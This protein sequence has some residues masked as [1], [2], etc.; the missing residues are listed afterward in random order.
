[1]KKK[2]Y[3]ILL[4][5]DFYIEEESNGYFIDRPVC[6]I[7]S[8]SSNFDGQAFNI[9]F[10][11]KIDGTHELSFELPQIYLDEETGINVRNPLI[12]LL[13]NKCKLEVQIEDKTYFMVINDRKEDENG[14]IISYSYSC[15]DAFIEELSKTGYGITFSDEIEGNGLG[16]I[17]ELAETI[18][19][20]SDWEYI[21]E[22]TGTLY[23]YT[24]DLSYNINQ[25]RYDK[26]Y[27]PIPVHPVKYIPELERYCNRLNMLR[28][29]TKD[30]KTVYQ[31]IYCY[32]DTEQI[33]SN[34][35]QNLIYNADD[36][37]DFIGWQTYG[38]EEN[39]IVPGVILDT[40]SRDTDNS[41][42][43]EYVLQIHTKGDST[44]Q[45]LLNDT[46]SSA[47]IYIQG[48]KPY[49]FYIDYETSSQFDGIYAI[50]FYSKNPLTNPTLAPE[51]SY[52]NSNGEKIPANTFITL[53]PKV[54]I[55]NPYI[56]F[57]F[58]T[59]NNNL[60]IKK[61]SLFEIKG[62]KTDGSITDDSEQNNLTLL[63][64]L[65]DGTVIS[66]EDLSIM[67]QP[68]DAISAYTQKSVRYFVR[69]NYAVPVSIGMKDF[70]ETTEN[71]LYWHDEDTVTYLD[72][73][74]EVN[75]TANIRYWR[76]P[77][78]SSKYTLNFNSPALKI[79]KNEENFNITLDD[80]DNIQGK[81]QIIYLP[82]DGKYYQYYQVE[83]NGIINGAWDY[84][85]YGVWENEVYSEDT[86][87]IANIVNSDKRR[88]LVTSRSNR[89][90]LIQDLAEL[91]KVWPVFNTYRDPITGK[92]IKQFWFRENCLKENFSGFHKGVNLDK[93]S[94]DIKSDD[95]VTKMYVE[96]QESDYAENGFVT[97]RTSPLNPW[98]ENYYYN[99]QYYVNQ[100]LINTLKENKPIVQYDLDELYTSVK[101][102]N[103][104][105]FDLNDKIANA[106]VELSNLRAR[107]T[108]LATMIAAMAERLTSL[109]ADIKKYESDEKDGVE[110]KDRLPDYTHALNSRSNY[111]TM[112]KKY[113]TEL[114]TTQEAYDVLENEY[115]SWK[116]QTDNLQ[117]EKKNLIDIFENKYSQYIKEGVWSDASYVDNNTYYI[118][119]LKVM[120]TSSMPKTDWTISIID[121]SI[122]DELQEF[123]FE[124]GDQTILVDNE[125]FGVTPNA[126][127]NYVFEVLISGIKEYLDNPTKN[128]IEVRNYL[129]SFEDIFQR[130]SAAT[131]TL[132]LNEQTYNKAAYFTNDGQVDESI[133]QN[134]LLKNTL[135][136][137]NSTDN[138]Y[139]LD[140]T[141]LYLQ[142]IIN[143]AK[144][145]RA[146]AD[147]IFISKETDI[148]TG[149]PKWTTGITADGIN[150]SILTSGEVNTSVVKIFSKGTPNF[151]WNELGITAYKYDNDGTV[152]SNAF[153]RFDSF[154]LYSTDET[155]SIGFNYDSNRQPWFEGLSRGEAITKILNNALVSITDKGF[156]LNVKNGEGSIKLG[157]DDEGTSYGLYI[158]DAEG[159]LTVQLQNDGKNK[160]AGWDIGQYQLS[161]YI[162]ANKKD[163]Q[164]NAL[165][166][167]FGLQTANVGTNALAI[168]L[169]KDPTK[170]WGDASFRV[171]HDGVLHATGADI[172]GSGTFSGV[173]KATSG[174]LGGWELTAN[175]I[176][177]I[178]YNTGNADTATV[179]YE[180]FMQNANTYANI[181]TDYWRAFGIYKNT[182]NSSSDTW[183]STESPF[184]VRSDGY[185]H[186][187]NANI[188]GKI[189]ATSGDF[190]DDVTIGGTSL[191]AEKIRKMYNAAVTGASAA[192]YIKYLGAIGGTVGGWNITDD[193]YL[194]SAGN[195]VV[196]DAKNGSISVSRTAGEDE[197]S[198]EIGN[199]MTSNG[200]I[201]ETPCIRFLDGN[202]SAGLFLSEGVLYV[203]FTRGTYYKVV[204]LATAF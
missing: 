63:A 174:N 68:A 176:R 69:D 156:N 35:V 116:Q 49:A 142:S 203:Y 107:L 136:L 80:I 72:F 148:K 18:A 101:G 144:K 134:T 196:L 139:T 172:E 59:P 77:E 133:L 164:G 56:V 175:R 1:M 162:D 94:R 130:I 67:C 154:G 15:T 62:K 103:N 157:Y 54:S 177:K 65:T 88:T 76:L 183:G 26:I 3:Q 46:A 155:N 138:S 113:Q 128:V 27:K 47:N 22:N 182:R 4:C 105:I 38:K 83:R 120:D 20:G 143:P 104:T 146:I 202:Y 97:I 13:V 71:A 21:A 25:A 89:F 132:E 166:Y 50:E 140:N 34:T 163:A 98:G 102:K 64:K 147:G 70:V 188:T 151:S 126:N 111:E 36:F 40:F 194:S 41:P 150:A 92:M 61:T 60:I 180:T 81:N 115:K 149:E 84:A 14:I 200:D 44:E 2:N 42:E 10:Y 28:P 86:V 108:S 145:L 57:C 9:E 141:G 112:Q 43:K 201:V 109:D 48:D 66:T 99:F 173:I 19:T 122:I 121:G 114:N 5:E 181:I 123:K 33:T 197:I 158:K 7:A 82:S 179:K 55:S 135:T 6:E 137:A 73:E 31:Y 51:Y 91:F 52:R 32:E 11:S 110:E 58:A 30:N 160:I 95:I 100:K 129:T 16:T 37:V 185:L 131:Q 39:E 165:Y 96:D 204:Q 90:N 168:G 171:T 79:I 53:K 189:T 195:E 187:T 119:S 184:Y 29:V 170:A 178:V 93:L 118:D 17:H 87:N 74:T 192:T 190:S 124:V 191:T 127:E 75:S 152:N 167:T 45:F 8:S 193:G 198:F 159:K 161:N 153:M 12:D 186:A 106:S 117:K 125:F 85:L 78:G 23:E 24:T 169:C 199:N